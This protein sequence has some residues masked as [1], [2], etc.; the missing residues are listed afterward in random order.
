MPMKKRPD[1][2]I[3]HKYACH[4]SKAKDRGIEF[5]LSYK[6]WW[7]IW[8]KSGQWENRGRGLGQY[9]MSRIND[10]GPYE[11]GN[12][13]IVPA[14]QNKREGNLGRKRPRTDEWQEK[15]IQSIR[16]TM[17][18]PNWI[19][20]NKGRKSKPAW[21][22]GMPSTTAAENGRKG[23][24]KVAAAKLGTKRVYRSDGSYTYEKPA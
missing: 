3:R 16:K 19:N 9:V 23:A 11:V 20:P 14:S 4:K 21:N 5:K 24:L 22:K 13:I 10:Q 7:D 18:D 2:V 17:S 1:H 8:E 12:V 15:L 6:E